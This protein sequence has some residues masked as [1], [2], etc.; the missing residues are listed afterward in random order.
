[1]SYYPQNLREEAQERLAT[2]LVAIMA[3]DL[4][5]RQDQEGL[6]AVFELMLMNGSIKNIIRR[7]NLVQLR[8]AIQSSADQGM[9]TMDAYA[10]QLAQQGAISQ[11][12]VN[13][14]VQRE[15]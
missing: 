8:T 13:Q 14:F 1:M 9:I 12:Q 11:E 6:V 10:Y 15:E 2:D 5:E 4:V 3:Q 7:G